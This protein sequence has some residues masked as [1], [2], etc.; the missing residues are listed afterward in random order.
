MINALTR[1]LVLTMLIALQ[2]QAEPAP[3]SGKLKIFL[4]AGQSNMVGFGQV[5]GRPGTME[6]YVKEKPKAYVH[7]VDPDG[8]PVVRDDVWIVN[9]SDPKN[10]QQG[11]LTTGY[12]ASPDH[13]GPEYGFGIEM[14]D[15]YEEPVLLIKCAWGGRSLFHNFLPPSAGD[16][17]KPEKDGDKGFHYTEILRITK[18][19]TGNLKTYYPHDSSQGFEIV[20]FGWHQGWN[21]RI[22]QTAVDAY[23]ENLVHLVQDLRRDLGIEKL[24][25]V[26]ANTGMGGWEIPKRYKAKV[27]KLMVAQ[28]ALAEPEK[29]PQFAGNV[30]GVETRDFQRSQEESPSKQEYHWMRNWETYYLIGESMAQSMIRL[31]DTPSAN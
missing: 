29:Y 30:G 3:Q 11:W 21:D 25:V 5:K 26:I 13:I 17:P 4:L 18:E 20:G 23:E 16:H 2:V 19:V 1:I 22:N 10:P 8:E 14:A 27:E 15:H 6:S 9:L 12:G 7:L 31:L 28:L 24:P